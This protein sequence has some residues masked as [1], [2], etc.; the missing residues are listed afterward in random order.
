MDSVPFRVLMITKYV[1]PA[2]SVGELR[3]TEVLW[4]AVAQMCFICSVL[5]NADNT[6]FCEKSW[7]CF[8][9]PI[10]VSANQ[11]ASRFDILHDNRILK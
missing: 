6:L 9:M 8:L 2:L 4:Q 11:K 5:H 7:P 10:E 1:S 3:G